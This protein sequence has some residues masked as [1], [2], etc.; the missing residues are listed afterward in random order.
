MLENNS[1]CLIITFSPY[2]INTFAFT[3]RFFN[4]EFSRPKYLQP[5]LLSM[6]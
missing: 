6:Q 3:T 1:K 2:K 5:I 4:F